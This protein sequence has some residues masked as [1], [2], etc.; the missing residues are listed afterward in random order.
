M[1]WRHVRWTHQPDVQDE[2]TSHEAH[3]CKLVEEFL[4]NSN[5]YHTQLLSPSDLICANKSISRWYGQCGHWI[6]LGLPMYMTTERN[7]ESGA[8][9][10]NAAC[11][12][13]G[14]MMQ[15]RIVKSARNEADKENDED[16]LPHGKKVDA[17]G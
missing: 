6:H 11:G 4:T 1:M 12:R 16:N 14:I 3:Q 10:Q 5:E 9:I 13:L 2:G 15:F 7:P 17:T 8:E